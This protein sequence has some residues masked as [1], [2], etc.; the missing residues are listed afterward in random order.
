MFADIQKLA[1][2]CAGQ[3][4]EYYLVYFETDYNVVKCPVSVTSLLEKVDSNNCAL[5]FDIDVEDIHNCVYSITV[6]MI[7]RA[8]RTNS[9]GSITLCKG[10]PAYYSN[11]SLCDLK[12]PI[13]LNSFGLLTD[14]QVIRNDVN[15]HCNFTHVL[16]HQCYIMAIGNAYYGAVLLEGE[17]SANH[18][19]TGLQSGIYTVLVYGVEEGDSFFQTDKPDFSTIIS[20]TKPQQTP[21]A[22]GSHSSGMQYVYSQTKVLSFPDTQPQCFN[23]T[24][25]F[26]FQG[27]KYLLHD[28]HNY[29]YLFSNRTR[30]WS[31]YWFC[32]NTHYN[33]HTSSGCNLC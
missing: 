15:I 2:L 11:N 14:M 9:S 20:L 27:G 6:E 26:T 8:G 31:L 30:V 21:V 18:T 1:G 25:H 10:L 4:P 5:S 22:H 29:T 13:L 32:G 23:T 12:S 33:Y 16:F 3:F 7:N 24:S 28:T 17:Q 19:F